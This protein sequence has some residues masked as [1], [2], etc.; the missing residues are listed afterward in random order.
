MLPNRFCIL[1]NQFKMLPNRFKILPNKNKILQYASIKS[2]NSMINWPKKVRFFATFYLNSTN[3]SKTWTFAWQSWEVLSNPATLDLTR[4]LKFSQV[5]QKC[6]AEKYDFDEGC[7]SWEMEQ[8]FQNRDPVQ[9]K[10]WLA[11]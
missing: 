6:L 8:H 5:V 1:P 3:S 7:F 10:S 11:S 9:Q 4:N 2:T